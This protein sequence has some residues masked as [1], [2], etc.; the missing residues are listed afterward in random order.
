MHKDVLYSF[1]NWFDNAFYVVEGV[2]QY[3]GSYSTQSITPNLFLNEY[4][5]EECACT[6]DIKLQKIFIMMSFQKCKS[7]SIAF[8]TYRELLCTN[9]YKITRVQ[10]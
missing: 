8:L 3:Y 9:A 10:C 6:Y 4:G 2:I 5:I 1:K 7:C